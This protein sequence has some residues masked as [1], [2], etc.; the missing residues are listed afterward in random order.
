ME[1][2]GFTCR[3]DAGAGLTDYVSMGLAGRLAK[4]SRALGP[5]SQ[6]ASKPLI[7]LHILQMISMS[8]SAT[9]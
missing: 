5:A 7:P 4:Y 9:M 8:E 6:P 2:T 3:T 1:G